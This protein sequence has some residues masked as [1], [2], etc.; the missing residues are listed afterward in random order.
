[1]FDRVTAGAR[2][3][4][5]FED[6]LS[7]TL[8]RTLRIPDDGEDHRLPPGMGQFPLYRVADYASRVPAHWLKTAG[9]NYFFP[10]YQREAMWISFH[11]DYYKPHA[12]KVGAGNIDA[13]T[14]KIWDDDLDARRHLSAKKQ[15][16]LV[17]PT[18][19][20]LDGFKAGKGI[21]KQFVAMPLGMGYTVEGQL[22][23]S[24]DFG[25]LQFVIVKAHE[26]KLPKRPAWD[27]S[28]ILRGGMVLQGSDW[29][30]QPVY[31]LRKRAAPSSSSFHGLDSHPVMAR[32]DMAPMAEMTVSAAPDGM[33]MGLGMGGRMTQVVNADPY[34]Y[35]TWNQDD[36]KL[37]NIWMVNSMMFREIT[38]Q[39]PPSTPVSAQAY[40]QHGYPWFS[41][42]DEK[43][44]DLEPTK[45]L[46]GVK[47]VKEMDQ[48]KGFGPQQDDSPIKLKPEQVV[49]IP[50]HAFEAEAGEG[51][52]PK[53]K[54]KRPYRK[55]DGPRLP[56]N[57]YR[58]NAKK[59]AKAN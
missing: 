41:L 45:P 54:P 8:M 50:K 22:T 56:K 6:G 53:G 29:S 40:S 34:G 55:I 15:N 24:E 1:M 7:I 35:Q 38:G 17:V 46:K 43:M 2:T 19:H 33:E 59:K 42:Y 26:A 4:L 57:P 10:L 58:K 9:D 23:G 20:W 14:G 21:I 5:D 52:K 30:G 47:S 18:Q 27:P 12:I 37:V 31:G 3:E 36:C 49:H 25:G 28:S 13:L 51:K 16:Y 44:P 39:E 32:M 11:G 48:G